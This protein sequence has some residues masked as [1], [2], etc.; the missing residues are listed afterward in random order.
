MSPNPAAA[1]CRRTSVGIALLVLASS[2]TARAADDVVA[3]DLGGSSLELRHIPGGTFTQGSPP[4]E[5][6]READ[7][8][9]RNVTISRSFWLG[10]VPVTR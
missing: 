1:S 10:K 2:G 7:E 6:G 9:R 3:L 5:P 8:A 4:S